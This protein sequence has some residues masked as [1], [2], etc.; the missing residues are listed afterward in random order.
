MSASISGMSFGTPLVMIHAIISH[1]TSSSCGSDPSQFRGQ[2]HIIFR[3]Y[4]RAQWSTTI[5]FHRAR[6]AFA[7]QRARIVRV[8]TKQ[9]TVHGDNIRIISALMDFF[10]VPLSAFCQIEFGKHRQ[11]VRFCKSACRAPGFTIPTNFLLQRQKFFVNA[12]FTAENGHDR[13]RARDSPAII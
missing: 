2:R 3:K 7:D 10:S 1:N 8:E 4:N 6:F 5:R 13:I 11:S 9:V 12:L